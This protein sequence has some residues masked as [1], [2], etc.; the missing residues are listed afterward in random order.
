MLSQSITLF[1]NTLS[2]AFQQSFPSKLCCCYS[3]HNNQRHLKLRSATTLPC[4]TSLL[5]TIAKTRV[6]NLLRVLSE[7]GRK[8][9]ISAGMMVVFV[10][11]QSS[12]PVV[13]IV[14][15]SI[16]DT[17]IMSSGFET[18]RII[19]CNTSSKLLPTTTV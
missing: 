14:D 1:A 17:H 3:I 10:N 7:K 9:L 12:I 5:P 18:Y 6:T 19:N 15:V 8:L 11:C 4:N 2:R 16:Y 13:A